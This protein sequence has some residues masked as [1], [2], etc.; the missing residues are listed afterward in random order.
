M[1][2][3][4][5]PSQLT[6]RAYN[7]GFGDC[8]LLTFHYEGVT[9]ER[10]VL[11]DFGTTGLP[12]DSG[13]NLMRGIAED[14]GARCGGKLHAVVAT[15]RHQD[16][17]SGFAT[18]GSGTGPGDIIAALNPSVVIQ[19]WTEHPDADPETGEVVTDA[20]A[21][22]G[23]LREMHNISAAALSEIANRKAAIGGVLHKEL[24]FLGEDNIKNHAAVVNLMEMGRSGRAVYVHHGSKSGLEKIL[25]GVKVRV[26]GP[27]TLKQSE[28]IRQQ[29]AE[30][31]AEFWHLQAAAVRFAA[32]GGSR[33]FPRAK[34]CAASGAP[35]HTRW[36]IRKLRRTRG[37]QLL[38]VMRA[39]D[40]AMNNTS[41]ILLIEVGDKK[42]LFPGDAQIEN[43]LYALSRE[44]N[45]ALL[46]DVSLYKVGHH[47]SLNATP[48]T[49]WE[50][51]ERRSEEKA[52]G[53]LQTVVS[54]KSGKHGKVSSNTEVPRRTLVEALKRE[55][56]FFST[57]EVKKKELF[58][59]LT[60]EL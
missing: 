60:I 3:P 47:G 21:F 33:L 14:I 40:E 10:H 16:H 4:K 26:L 11:I 19:P 28:A 23:A 18:N 41:I 38:S 7:V 43:W 44:E 42:L 48:K 34:T 17:I 24:S 52:K 12:E 49:L 2:A 22:V 39:L 8:F 51:F 53:R 29:R 6:L 37:E 5:K 35:P 45:R 27:P 58:R 32:R 56:D 15:H 20:Q 31:D 50:M 46:A 55:S 36:F 30:D 13:A 9:G 57:Q 59:E 25:P 1:P 54:T